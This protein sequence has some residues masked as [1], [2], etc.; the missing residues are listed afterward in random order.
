[1]EVPEVPRHRVIQAIRVRRDMVLQGVQPQV[2]LSMVVLPLAIQYAVFK[3]ITD[4][5]KARSPQ[6]WTQET[7]GK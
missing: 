5:N 7:L 3:R 1:M 4:K 6:R 2:V